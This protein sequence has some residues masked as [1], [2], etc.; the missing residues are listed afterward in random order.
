M[1]PR[2]W[3]RIKKVFFA[4]TPNAGSRL[5]DSDHLID[6]LDVYTNLLTQL[7]DGATTYTI[8]TI[9]AI[10]KLVVHSTERSLPGIGA[11]STGANGYIAQP[12]IHA[13]QSR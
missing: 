7:P 1:P 2:L 11:M 6:L 4:G 10:L 12:S 8:E 5:G 3:Q 13:G 9:L